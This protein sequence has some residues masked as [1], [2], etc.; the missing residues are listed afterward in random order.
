M[1]R[2]YSRSGEPMDLF[3]W[4]KEFEKGNSVARDVFDTPNG[5]VKVSTVWLGLDHSFGK[6]G[7]PLIF[8]T[9][10]FG[11]GAEWDEYQERYATEVE[12]LA[13]HAEI[14]ATLKAVTV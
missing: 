6:S 4:A 7:P 14:V 9:M 8:E 1:S 12:A 13:R 5:E 10:V 2:Y 3:T 11:G